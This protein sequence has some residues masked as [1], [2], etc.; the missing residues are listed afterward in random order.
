MRQRITKA[1]AKLDERDPLHTHLKKV[2]LPRLGFEI[3]QP[4]FELVSLS[5]QLT[6]FLYR[7]RKSNALIVGKFFGHRTKQPENDPQRSLDLEFNNLVQTRKKGLNNPPCQVVRPLS[8]NKRLKCVLI[9]DFI[10]GRD[11]DHYIAK[12]AYEGK[13]HQLMDK[14][15]TLAIFLAH[16]HK[17][18]AVKTQVNNGE[19]TVS[20]THLRA[21]ET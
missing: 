2:V 12:A 4:D 20:Y 15:H 3:A 17:M 7:E 13:N 18:M 11:L 10:P 19:N 16:L 9:E 14:L 5:K 1:F 21:H 6:V 8:K